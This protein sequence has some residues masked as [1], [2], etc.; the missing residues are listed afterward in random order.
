M[1]FI[2]EYGI[3]RTLEE[4]PAFKSISEKAAQFD[5]LQE[6]FEGL[7]K[8]LAKDA[9]D[10][11]TKEYQQEYSRLQSA[12]DTAM[13]KAITEVLGIESNP[14][15]GEWM[16]QPDQDVDFDYDR[17]ESHVWNAAMK[18]RQSTGQGG[19]PWPLS[20]DEIV[21]AA[22]KLQPYYQVQDLNGAQRVA[23]GQ[24]NKPKSAPPRGGG[25]AASKSPGPVPRTEEEFRESMRAE[26]RMSRE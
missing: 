13:K 9:E 21:F 18:Y 17:A 3:V 8:R 26:L 22:Q 7:E 2:D 15:K 14:I 11:K 19:N 12:S 1:K 5:K 23:A 16:G 20:P 10:G 25:G 4:H 24:R 6:R